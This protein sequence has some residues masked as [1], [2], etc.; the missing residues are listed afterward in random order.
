MRPGHFGQPAVDRHN[1]GL[2]TILIEFFS[3]VNW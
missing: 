2:R 3:Y 1:H